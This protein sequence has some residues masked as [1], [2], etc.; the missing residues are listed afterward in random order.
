MSES[1]AIVPPSSADLRRELAGLDAKLSD[2]SEKSRAAGDKLRELSLAIVR[3]DSTANGRAVQ[4]KKLLGEVADEI[5]LVTAA[6]GVLST[7]IAAALEREAAEVRA[8]V[9]AE[10]RGFAD[11]IEPIGA[12]LDELTAK[13]KSTYLSLKRSLS[14]A[15]QGGY[16]PNA[17]IVGTL[18][19]EA[20]R[21]A[22]WDIPELKL[23]PPHTSIR[24]S[25]ASLTTS[26]AGGARGAAERLL[27]PPGTSLPRR[28]GHPPPV[29]QV[30]GVPAE[31]L[32]P[33]R[34]DLTESLP[35]D[36]PTFRAYDPNGG[37]Q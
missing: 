30:L 27:L 21:G 6:K 19:S 4:L 2:L 31:R 36:D 24:R 7:E 1:S 8:G 25:C 3:N 18:L 32:I 16:G 34:V 17:N 28:N 10:A 9:A 13:L 20:F 12:E 26:W 15:Q 23:E 11:K 37:Q 33:K 14:A 35:G 29:E 5:E 22:L